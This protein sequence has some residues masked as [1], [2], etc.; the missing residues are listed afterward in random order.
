MTF[1]QFVLAAVVGTVFAVLLGI[2]AYYSDKSGSSDEYLDS[3]TGQG[4]VV[5]AL[6]AIGLRRALKMPVVRETL[7]IC[8]YA[9][10]IVWPI[11]LAVAVYQAVTHG[12][13]EVKLQGTHI[14]LHEGDFWKPRVFNGDYAD[15]ESLTS[16]LRGKE[17]SGMAD[18]CLIF[19]KK[20][21]STEYAIPYGHSLTPAI[22]QSILEQYKTYSDHD[23]ATKVAQEIKQKGLQSFDTQQ[24]VLNYFNADK[25]HV[26]DRFIEERISLLQKRL[27]EQGVTD[28]DVT[29]DKARYWERSLTLS[30][31]KQAPFK[32]ALKP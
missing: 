30:T 26:Q 15:I 23:I 6:A 7:K 25:E 1:D 4:G 9:L 20:G 32:L 16:G 19:V 8:G 2:L 31:P 11:F 3:W 28:C 22:A 21:S 18:M 29:F 17:G 5:P 27:V 13:N 12:L 10:V 14:Y 24:A